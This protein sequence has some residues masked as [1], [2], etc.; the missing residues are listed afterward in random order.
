MRW[1]KTDGQKIDVDSH[2]DDLVAYLKEVE[3]VVAVYLFGSYGTR[4]QTPLSD[5]DLAIVF[6]AGAE[7][8]LHEE[9]RLAAEVSRI[10]RQDDVS[11]TN[12]NRAP[13]ILQHRV[14]ADGRPLWVSDR[15]ALADFVEDVLRHH[16]D[17]AL[18][19]ERFLREY[20]Q[21]LIEAYAR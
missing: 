13:V 8:S 1:L 5:V 9:L 20:E 21:S 19:H 14:I 16:G 15:T 10:L 2:L 11:I 17:F 12:L 3:G 18:K 4:Y 6:R 7:P